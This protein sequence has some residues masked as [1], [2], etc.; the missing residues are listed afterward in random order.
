[1]TIPNTLPVFFSAPSLIGEGPPP[2]SPVLRYAGG[3][4][5]CVQC[6]YPIVVQQPVA[7]PPPPPRIIG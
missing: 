6:T 1:M 7:P 2:P 4:V 5:M 3:S